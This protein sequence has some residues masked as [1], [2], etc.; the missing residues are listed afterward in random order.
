MGPILTGA[1]CYFCFSSVLHAEEFGLFSYREVGETIE[2]TDY[3]TSA[4]G[5][6]TIPSEIV[7]KPVTAIGGGGV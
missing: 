3:P 4:T 7:G 5:S 6:V 1:V 2:I